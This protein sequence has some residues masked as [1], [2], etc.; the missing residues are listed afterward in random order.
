MNLG[1]ISLNC[2]SLYARLAEVKLLL[3]SVK[4]SVMCPTEM[5]VKEEYFP[6]FHGFS[7]SWRNRNGQGGGICILVDH[8]LWCI[9]MGGFLRF[10]RLRFG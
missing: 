9:L 2:N 6:S 5:W 1:V 10:K 8:F 3:Y 7:A 4:P